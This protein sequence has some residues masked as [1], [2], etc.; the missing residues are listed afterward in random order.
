MNDI[1]ALLGEARACIDA[2]WEAR[3][4]TSGP[5]IPADNFTMATVQRLQSLRRSIDTALAEKAPEPFIW[6]HPGKKPPNL[7]ISYKGEGWIPLYAARPPASRSDARD[8]ERWKTRADWLLHNAGQ[9]NAWAQMWSPESSVTL[10]RYLELLVD[11]AIARE[12]K[13]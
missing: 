10:I 11:A 7:S 13:S 12:A 1:R 5:D 2:L 4:T 8:A 3:Q 9:V 6:F